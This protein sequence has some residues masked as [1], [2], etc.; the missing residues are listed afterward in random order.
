MAVRSE[1]WAANAARIR[2]RSAV[3]VLGGFVTTIGCS[4]GFDDGGSGVDVS[5]QN[6]TFNVEDKRS[7]EAVAARNAEL[8]A[9]VM[10]GHE[11]RGRE[12]VATTIIADG[13]TVDWVDA[14]TVYDQSAPPPAPPP[15]PPSPE[16]VEYSMAEEVHGPPGTVPYLRP[17]FE[18]YLNGNAKEATV[19]EF[20]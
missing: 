19:E 2:I 1:R 4:E 16:G 20:A 5:E 14:A 7:P 8:E 3:I 6:L 9:W 18:E 17:V 13:R 15:L 12:V 10:R 11:K